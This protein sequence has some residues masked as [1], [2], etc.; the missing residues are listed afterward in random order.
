VADV[1]AGNRKHEINHHPAVQGEGIN[2]ALIHDCAHARVLR[3]QQF[4][5]GLHVHRLV[6]SADAQLEI[7]CGLLPHFEIDRLLRLRKALA[8]NRERV[9]ARLQTCDLVQPGCV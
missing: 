9:R 2:R 1:R 7:D 8:L 3:L 4:A 6:V 5:G